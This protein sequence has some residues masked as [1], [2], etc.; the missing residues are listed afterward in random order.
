[1][2]L[3]QQ[4]SKMAQHVHGPSGCLRNHVVLSFFRW[5]K[6]WTT[7]LT[8]VWVSRCNPITQSVSINPASNEIKNSLSCN[9]QSLFFPYVIVHPP[10]IRPTKT[11]P[12]HGGCKS[13]CFFAAKKHKTRVALFAF[14]PLLRALYGI[15][16]HHCSFISACL[17]PY[18]KGVALGRYP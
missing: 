5:K 2:G 10:R 14:V 11:P 17:G 16:N 1:M 18:L 3:A 15:I 13:I 4:I 12:N 8:S 7:T 9:N 6:N